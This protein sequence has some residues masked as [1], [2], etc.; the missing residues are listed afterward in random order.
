MRQLFCSLLVQHIRSR[1]LTVLMTLAIIVVAA[2]TLTPATAHAQTSATPTSVRGAL[3][4]SLL[5]SS[6]VP[7]SASGCNQSVCI[8]VIGSGLYVD[9][10]SSTGTTTARTI[11]VVGQMLV[12]GS[13]RLTTN[14]IS[15]IN[16]PGNLVLLSAYY[17]VGYNINNGSQ[18]CVRFVGTGAPAG[19]PCETIH[20]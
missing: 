13:V 15:M 1:Y 3:T 20:S 18:V 8:T 19:L 17:P 11:N 10:V 7:N 6:V 14:T 9:H 16:S 5:G 4:V 2:V 12:R